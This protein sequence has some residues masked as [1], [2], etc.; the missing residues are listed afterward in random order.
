MFYHTKF[1]RPSYV[2]YWRGISADS[3]PPN[4]RFLEVV[5]IV[6]AVY[7]LLFKAH[8]VHVNDAGVDNGASKH[9]TRFHVIPPS[10]PI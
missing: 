6:W 9:T 10:T 2:F 4:E 5:K 3:V 1:I 8:V 7:L